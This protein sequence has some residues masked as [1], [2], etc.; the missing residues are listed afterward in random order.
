MG[1]REERERERGVEVSARVRCS[2][3]ASYAILKKNSPHSSDSVPP[4]SPSVLVQMEHV[5]FSASTTARD[6][7]GV[8]GPSTSSSAGQ[9][10]A[11]KATSVDD[12]DACSLE[13]PISVLSAFF[14]AS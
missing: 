3:N 14:I 6:E 5:S 2:S 10:E 12:V 13:P 8:E 1:A 9:I 4:F 7:L 11:V